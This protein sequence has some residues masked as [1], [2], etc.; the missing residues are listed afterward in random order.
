V[1]KQKSAMGQLRNQVNEASKDSAKEIEIEVENINGQ[2]E[3]QKE[4]LA[5]KHASEVECLRQELRQLNEDRVMLIT[6]NEN[7]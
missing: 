5:R 2:F 7:L 3:R 6:R 4:A 1:S